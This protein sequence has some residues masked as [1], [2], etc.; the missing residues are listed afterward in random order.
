MSFFPLQVQPYSLAGSGAITGATSII[1]KSMLDIDGNLVTMSQFGQ[2]G[3]ATIDPGNNS[4]EEQ[5]SFTNIVQNANGTAT[6]TGVSS[7]TFATPYTATSGLMKTHAG[8]TTLVISNTSG[9]YNEYPSKVNDETITGLWSVPDPVNNA[10]IANKEYVLSVVN[11]GTVT[12][13]QQIVSGTAGEGI[14]A[15]N[16][17]YLKASDQRWYKSTSADSTTF[18]DVT[19]GIAQ[20]TVSAAGT[21][22]IL[23]SGITTNESGLSAGTKYYVGIGGALTT[24]S[25]TALIGTAITSTNLLMQNPYLDALVGNSGLPS[26]ANR[27][28]TESGLVSTTI[29]ADGSDGDVTIAA[30]TTTLTRDMYYHNLIVTGTLVTDGF[31]IFVSGTLSGAGTISWGT[32]NNGAV[33][34]TGSAGGA[35][36]AQSGSGALKNLAGVQGSSSQDTNG[37][38][39]L[40]G[41]MGQA[42]VAGGNGGGGTGVGGI[43]GTFNK[44]TANALSVSSLGRFGINQKSDL[45]FESFKSATGGSGAAGGGGS[46]GT[47]GLGGG[48]GASGG[49][50]VIF[51]KTWSGSFSIT[52]VG[53]NG[54]A[55]SAASSNRGGGGGGAGGNG[56]NT[57]VIYGTKTWTGTYTITG[58][59]PGA[60]GSGGSGSGATGIAG[61]SGVSVELA[62]STII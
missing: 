10:N 55:G 40:A 59:T 29:F 36:G 23:L 34:V 52:T 27:Y 57:I 15:G 46:S 20:N 51:V 38:A 2:I 37:A 62:A 21:F 45:T 28:V 26:S 25:T 7:V 6:L 4:L 47:P 42:G 41:N 5:I 30:G 54:G 58:G 61:A 33:G 32:P 24:A 44:S 8:S 12:F 35:G 17:I 13:S 53:G 39:G 49:T 48:S 1:L 16:A 9:F 43:A 22:N 14:T 50:V 18:I 11:G 19:I 31:R 60:G 3:F 56:G